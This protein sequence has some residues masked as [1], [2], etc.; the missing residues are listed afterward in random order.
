VWVV[1]SGIFVG[2]L[3]VSVP[4]YARTFQDFR[5]RLPWMTE[6][7]VAA[8]RYAWRFWFLVPLVFIIG[9][10]LVAG[11]TYLIRHRSGNRWLN[12]VW[13]LV[14]IGVPFVANVALLAALWIPF[15]DLHQGLA[16]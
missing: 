16:K 11:V 10:G 13:V 6:M 4:G 15:R 12:V 7:A 1:L 14:L 5:M 2:Q 8:S 3:I 9:F